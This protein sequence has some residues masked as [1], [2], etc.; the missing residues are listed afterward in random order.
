MDTYDL[1]VIGAGPGGYVAAVEGARLGMSVALIEKEHVGGLCLNWGCIPSKILLKK[2]NVIESMRKM[3]T[4]GEIEGSWE[5]HF[6]KIIEESRAQVEVIRQE[7]G[8]LIKKN[9]VEITYGTATFKNK[10][11]VEVTSSEGNKIC[12]AKKGIIIAT[13]AGT[14]TLPNIP[15]D[16]KRIITSK[17]ALSLTHLPRSIA[18]IGAGVTGC[19]MASF[20]AS[21][22]SDVT[23]IEFQ[24][25]V[26]PGIDE[27]ISKTLERAFK[28]RG[29]TLMLKTAVDRCEAK[30]DHVDIYLK[31]KEPTKAEYVLSAVGIIAH[32][33]GL[34]I[35]ELGIETQK[36]FIL[37]DPETYRTNVEGIYAIGDV[38]AFLDRPHPPMAHVASAE[39]E[40]AAE[41]I[42][43][44]YANW[45]INYDLI[46]SAIFTE[47]EIGS[48][49]L[50]ETK[51][52][53]VHGENGIDVQIVRDSW[54]GVGIALK[55]AG[56]TKIIREKRYKSIVGAHMIGAGATERIHAC[57]V[58]IRA[59]ETTDTMRKQIMAH[60]TYSEAIREALL[61]FDGLAVH[62]PMMH[63][64]ERHDH[65][66][67]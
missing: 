39:G 21:L 42:A 38:I 56:L 62:V 55:H 40:I 67:T 66:N 41:H 25:R 5:I 10:T 47:P 12:T 43:R 6:R 51:A 45:K 14:R 54:M 17:E 44:N 7:L 50:S 26:L 59:E 53:E 15:V 29:I 3:T 34:G 22:G 28:N 33:E 46:P 20:Y 49:G 2:G 8:G 64:G 57:A 48:V 60:P 27:E 36:G 19:E 58:A 24:E 52:K 18:V 11:Q 32:T 13:G 61:A 1:I 23:I 65:K 37:A 63:Q 35:E 30:E 4:S 16:G 9:L 31:D